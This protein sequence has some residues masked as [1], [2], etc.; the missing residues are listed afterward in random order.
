[1]AFIIKSL[2]SGLFLILL[3]FSIFPTKMFAEQVDIPINNTPI[4]SAV[5]SQSNAAIT[6]DG[7]NGAIIAWVDNRPGTYQPFI[8]AQRLDK[9]G[10]I[11]W[12]SDGVKVSDLMYYSEPPVIKVISDGNGGAII[13]WFDNPTGDYRMY[14]QKINMNGT[15]Q[16]TANGLEI[17]SD[18]HQYLSPNMISDE[19]GGAIITWATNSSGNVN[20]YAQRINANGA[21]QW[22]TSGVAISTAIN[23]YS[24]YIHPEICSD[25]HGGAIIVW[26]AGRNGNGIYAQ[27]V[28][29]AGEVQWMSNGVTITTNGVFGSIVSDGKD[30]AMIVFGNLSANNTTYIQRINSSG[31]VQW[32]DAG[33]PT[34]YVLTTNGF[35][36]TDDGNGGVVFVWSDGTTYHRNIYAQ[37]IDTA[38]AA[39]WGNNGLS[40][41]SEAGEQGFPS[42]IKDKKGGFI[43]A[44]VDERNNGGEIY[45]QKINDSG[46]IQWKT[47]GVIITNRLF[48][49]NFSMVSD[50][51]GG[52]I[53]TWDDT[54]GDEIDTDIYAQHIDSTGNYSEITQKGDVNGDGDVTLTDSILA[55]QVLAGQ[56]LLTIN[57]DSEVDGDGKVGL[58][59]AIYV[60]RKAAGL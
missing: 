60:I 52:A 45:A 11:R 12:N 6:D 22:G 58:A 59:E 17:G 19:Q 8:Y 51:Y 18:V 29:S 43:I 34:P 13:A 14:L 15:P 30:G 26:A 31:I 38:G 16:W 56:Q 10:M 3:L 47:A 9:S 21:L 55:M 40:I 57:L 27:R 35:S 41:C 23:N 25:G 50:G 4:C 28:N 42:I 24:N 46:A 36:M 54:R 5:G 2:S 49:I 7:D 48:L 44:W 39:R 37:R 1:M 20:L 32:T 33:I 53:F